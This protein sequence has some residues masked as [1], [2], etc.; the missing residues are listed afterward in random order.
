MR[1]L[2]RVGSKGPYYAGEDRWVD[3]RTD[4][5]DL[6][7]LERAAEVGRKADRESMQIVVT[8]GDAGADWFMPLRRESRGDG[9]VVSPAVQALMRMAA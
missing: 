9:Q 3:N 5:L 6:G 2:L 8:Y 1:V 4:A 7:T